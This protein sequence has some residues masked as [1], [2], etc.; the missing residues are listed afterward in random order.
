MEAPGVEPDRW[1]SGQ[2]VDLVPNDRPR[3]ARA[4]SSLRARGVLS[5]GSLERLPGWSAWWAFAAVGLFATVDLVRTVLAMRGAMARR[6]EMEREIS[7]RIL[8]TI[9]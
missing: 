2:H 5:F 9:Q 6:E 4:E 3:G 7:Q 8:A 1:A